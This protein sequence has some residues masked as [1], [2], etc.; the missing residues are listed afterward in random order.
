MNSTLNL[1]EISLRAIERQS[2][3][4]HCVKL[5]RELGGASLNKSRYCIKV[6]INKGLVK[7]CD[8][9]NNQNKLNKIYFLGQVALRASSAHGTLLERKGS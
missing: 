6:A 1:D 2:G 7:M 5:S 8:F 9:S 4:T 3:L